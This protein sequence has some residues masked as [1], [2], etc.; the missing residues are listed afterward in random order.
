MSRALIL[1]FSLVPA[2]SWADC[3]S[4]SSQLSMAEQQVVAFN[5]AGVDE[6]LG[7]AIKSFG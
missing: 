3:P 6:Y 1:A 4:V 5:M 2:V 7:E